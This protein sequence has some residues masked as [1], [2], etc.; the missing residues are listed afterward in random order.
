MH[1]DNQLV[2]LC[3]NHSGAELAVVDIFGRTSV[4]MITNALNRIAAVRRCA[5]DPEDNISALIGLMWLHTE[6]S[7]KF[8]QELRNLCCWL[9]TSLS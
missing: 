8:P 2:H 7:V 3:W 5:T 1:S 4:F 6:K 9:T